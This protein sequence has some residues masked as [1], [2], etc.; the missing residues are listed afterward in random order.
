MDGG[1]EHLIIFNGR[2][3]NVP[4]VSVFVRFSVLN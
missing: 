2:V 3:T 4:C 1:N